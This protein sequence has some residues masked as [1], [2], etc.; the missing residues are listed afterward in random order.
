MFLGLIISFLENTFQRVVS[1]VKH[2]HGD[3]RSTSGLCFRDSVLPYLHTWLVKTS[4]LTLNSLRWWSIFSC[5]HRSIK[6]WFR[7]NSNWAH[8]WKMPLPCTFFWQFFSFFQR[9]CSGKV[10]KSEVFRYSL[11]WKTRFQ[12]SHKRED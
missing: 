2:P 11:R 12:C 5:F 9:H 8:Q 3:S 4:H 10:Q 1:M 7:K 6:Q